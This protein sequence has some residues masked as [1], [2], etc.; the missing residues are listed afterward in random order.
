VADEAVADPRPKYAGIGLAIAAGVA[1]ILWFG[2]WGA[3]SKV[4][5]RYEASSRLDE[6]LDE[7]RW[8]DPVPDVARRP[9]AR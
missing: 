1:A 8:V 4:R 2:L 6:I 5:A 9:G 7:A 3:M